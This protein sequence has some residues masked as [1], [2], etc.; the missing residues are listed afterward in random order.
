M[1]TTRLFR[2]HKTQAVRLPKSV[3]FASEVDEV[4]II[5]AGDARI[6]TPVAKRWD[7][8]F[9]SPLTVSDDYLNDRDQPV[10]QERGEW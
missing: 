4:E 1:V 3:A 7:V 9:T 8:F 5:V 10:A 2:T 6:I